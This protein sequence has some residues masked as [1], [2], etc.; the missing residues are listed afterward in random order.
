MQ[1]LAPTPDDVKVV[2]SSSIA[3]A[4]TQDAQQIGRLLQAAV[5]RVR[6][7]IFAIGKV[8][9]D[10]DTNSVPP[11]GWRHTIVLAARD[12]VGNTT[13]PEYVSKEW[14]SSVGKAER[15][16]EYI[17]DGGVVSYPDNPEL[18]NDGSGDLSRDPVR[19]GSES[20]LVDLETDVAGG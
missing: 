8:P 13:V 20:D 4:V 6:G 11:E 7:L 12:L 3:D 1:W 9:L 15:W 2:L 18:A 14:N 16:L 19:W 10:Q 17:Q 5:L